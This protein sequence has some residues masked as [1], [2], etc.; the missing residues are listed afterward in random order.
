VDFAHDLPAGSLI[1]RDLAP[2][3]VADRT[4]NLWHIASLWVGMSVCIPTYMLAASMIDAG[5][6][7]RQSLA[8]ILLGNAIVLV[9]MVITAHAGTRYGIPFPVFARAAFGIRGAHVPSLLRSVVACGWFGIQT[10]VGGLA[11]NALIGILWPA[12]RSLGGGWRFMGSGAPE[13]ASFLLFWSLNLYFVWA[14]TESIKWLETASAPLLILLGLSL[15]AWAA[16]KVGGLGAILQQADALE[17]S[18]PALPTAVFLRLLFVPWVTAMV[19]YWATLSLNIPDFTRYARSQRDQAAGQALGLLTTMPLFAFIGVAVTSA[20]VILYGRAIWNPVDLLTRLTAESHSPL[21]GI[22]A[23]IAIAVATLTTNIA[24]NIVAPANSFANLSPRRITFR[25]GGLIA[26]TLGILI[27]PW[28]LLDV[29]Q[30]WL[31]TYSGLLGAVAGVLICDYAIIRRGQLS[32]TD[33]Y[34]ENGVYSYT[35]GVNR[36]A[37]VALAAGIVLAL[38]GL[39]DPWLHLL[40]DAAWFTAGAASFVVYYFLMA[41]RPGEGEP[42]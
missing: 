14:G 13:F 22:V 40:F 7:W 2:T 37:I 10:W 21:I 41:G 16:S 5:M 34:S 35:N 32:V 9:P 24:A 28:K 18:R 31:I 39:G 26:G 12:W 19:G 3:R 6:T 11:I 42:V 20:T 27:V 8:A 23:M 1:N 17:R 36:S 15:L 38:A 30:A 33:L 29:Y 4:W 25:L